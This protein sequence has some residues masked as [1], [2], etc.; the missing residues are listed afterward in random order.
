M[1]QV[2]EE[3]EISWSNVLPLADA[4][5]AATLHGER[6]RA[7][8]NRCMAEISTWTSGVLKQVESVKEELVE[9]VKQVHT[10]A[11]EAATHE[12]ND[13]RKHGSTTFKADFKAFNL[14]ISP[15]LEALLYSGEKL[16]SIT[17][18]P[19]LPSQLSLQ[20]ATL[21]SQSMATVTCSVVA[22]KG[23]KITKAVRRSLQLKVTTESGVDITCR[24]EMA[25]GKSRLLFTFPAQHEERYEVVAML[26]S[27]HIPGSPLIIPPCSGLE[28]V[29]SELGL[30]FKKGNE[31]ID[32]KEF[33]KMK[34][35]PELREITSYVET[36]VKA[37][38]D[39][40]G[41]VNKLSSLK[42]VLRREVV[43]GKTQGQ[44]Q[45]VILTQE[46]TVK[47]EKGKALEVDYPSSLKQVLGNEV[48]KGMCQD[49]PYQDQDVQ[50][51]LRRPGSLPVRTSTGQLERQP[52]PENADPLERTT[53]GTEGNLKPKSDVV[54]LL[55]EQ[56]VRLRQPIDNS[57]QAGPML[58]E[59]DAQSSAIPSHLV[60][61]VAEHLQTRIGRAGKK[62]EAGASCY[63]LE[64]D[65]NMWHAGCVH[66]IVN[67]NLI[68]VKNLDNQQFSGCPRD[69]VVLSIEDIPDG[70]MCADSAKKNFNKKCEEREVSIHHPA[71]QLGEKCVARWSEDLVWY[72]AEILTTT[73]TITV[74]FIDYGNEA[75]VGE[76]DIVSAGWEVPA[77]DVDAGL[78][79]CGVVL[80]REEESDTR[81]DNE[82]AWSAG[83]TCLARWEVDG[84]WYRAKV[85]EA[86]SGRSTRVLFVDYGNQDDATALVRTAAELGEDDVKDQ[87]AVENQTFEGDDAKPAEADVEESGEIELKDDDISELACCVCAKLK[88]AMHRVQCDRSPV[89]WNCAVKKI[90]SNK[91]TCWRC[92]AS[93]VSSE[94]HLV[95]DPVLDLC[96]REYLARGK[97]NAADLEELRQS[98]LGHVGLDL[99]SLVTNGVLM[100]RKQ[101]V[102]LAKQ[103]V[104]VAI[105]EDEVLVVSQGNVL[106]FSKQGEARGHLTSA[107]PL[108][109]PS[110]ILRLSSGR[111]A[112]AHAEGVAFFS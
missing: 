33:E 74:Q 6:I 60:D 16:A 76:C 14:A 37:E 41:E 109:H 27:L 56:S 42:Q 107:K 95:K 50:A 97:L 38:E 28:T 80:E 58:V 87:D 46:Q 54:N 62:M 2:K 31:E 44:E 17:D 69:Q 45:E 40:D 112:V 13:I 88:K 52:E 35:A 105:A 68:V 24:E 106:R 63:L 90:T 100:A 9:E 102:I 94:S 55:M 11:E 85:V 79:D 64:K 98:R 48:L 84:V 5:R 78:V 71:F 75:E 89:C 19:L 67:G 23:Q 86:S 43:K 39:T 72:R 12:E 104:G 61:V 108:K 15:R 66:N 91:H 92:S 96:A 1:A 110:D 21:S 77:E 99:G 26:A 32:S 59:S 22:T 29:A 36:K 103:P 7:S 81:L 82:Q 34:S 49:Q 65:T 20:L 101:L 73:P 30:L 70:A 111:L 25:E 53:N 47:S 51:K 3:V 18:S 8:Q 4:L 93:S 10:E 83:E 57:V